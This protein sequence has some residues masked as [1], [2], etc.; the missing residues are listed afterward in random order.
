M[1]GK[2][3]LCFLY[4]AAR[5]KTNIDQLMYINIYTHILG[6]RMNIYYITFNT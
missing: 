6:F 1:R 5:A 3:K 4:E 2:L